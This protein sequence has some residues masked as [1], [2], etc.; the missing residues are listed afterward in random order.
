MFAALAIR[1]LILTGA[2]LNEIMTLQWA[3]VDLQRA[4][5]F[6]PDSKTGKKPLRLSAP[7]IALLEQAPR[8]DGNPFVIVGFVEGSHLVNLQ[9]PWRSVRDLAGLPDVRIHDLRHTFASMAAASGASFP[10]IGKL[11]GHS[12]PQTTARYAHLADDP[13]Q[14]LNDDVGTAISNAMRG[15]GPALPNS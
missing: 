10:M 8:V 6:L 11:L 12:Q 14:K 13:I 15:R 3:H 7:A 5:L 2:R 4:F 9:K 1:L